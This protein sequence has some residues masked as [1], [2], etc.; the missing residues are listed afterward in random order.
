MSLFESGFC[1]DNKLPPETAHG[2]GHYEIWKCC[3]STSKMHASVLQN[4]RVLGCML[5]NGLLVGVPQLH[6]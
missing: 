1:I 4:L 2:P 6:A 3:Q 5:L